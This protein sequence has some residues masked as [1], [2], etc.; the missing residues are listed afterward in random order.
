M[1]KYKISKQM[2]FSCKKLSLLPDTSHRTYFD[3]V[4]KNNKMKSS[5]ATCYME[6]GNIQ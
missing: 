4:D 2:K 5:R 3:I 1:R 6:N